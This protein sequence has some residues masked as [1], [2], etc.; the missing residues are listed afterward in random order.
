M[1][2]PDTPATRTAA[3]DRAS[4]SWERATLREV[5]L[6]AIAEQR[7]ARRWNVALRLGF[8][9]YLVALLVLA[10]GDLFVA[11]APAGRHTALVDLDGLIAV[12][13][14]ANADD[15][16]EGLTNAFESPGVAGVVLRVN[17]PGGSPVQSGRINAAVRRLRAEHPKVPVYAV[18]EDLCASGGYYVAVAAT[19]IY[20]DKASIVGS[21]G[22]RM[23]GFGFVE[24]MEKL[25]VQRRLITAGTHKGFLDPFSPLDPADES[26]AKA[27]LGNVHEQ[28]IQVVREGRG[29]RLREVPELYSGWIWTGEQALD[30]GL[31]DALGDVEF[32]AREVIGAKD[33]VDYTRRPGY[34]DQFAR[35]LG[36]RFAAGAVEALAQRS[37]SLR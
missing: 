13:A 9:L 36:A 3:P 27:L 18:V 28:F 5:A 17:S 35:Q 33:I 14:P 8:L 21:I 24:T 25:G 15:V 12:D 7:R 16:I 22:V 32:V 10:R 30:L 31:V 4:D 1:P 34:F 37:A 29:K 2:D 6:A 23:D 19:E 20:A 26:H 11:M